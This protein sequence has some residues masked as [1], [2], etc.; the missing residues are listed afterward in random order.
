MLKIIRSG[1]LTTLQDG[2]RPGYQGM[3]VSP[4]GA[5]DTFAMQI[6]NTLVGNP[7][8]DAALEMTFQGAA[9]TF[10]CDT[11]IA[12][13]GAPI[14][15]EGKLA[16]LWRPLWVK[17][18]ITLDL[19]AMP[20]GARTYLCVQGGFEVPR[21]LGGAGTDL[22]N[23]FGGGF[24]RALSAGDSLAVAPQD[25][26]Y[27]SL[28]RR[29]Q[30]SDDRFVFPAW[31][32]SCWRD[33]LPFPLQA[34][35]FL[36][37][38]MGRED[39]GTIYAQLESTAFVVST[40]SDRQGLRLLGEPMGTTL[41]RQPSAGVCVGT[42][43]LPPDGQPILLLAD[44]Q[45]TGGY[46]VPGVVPTVAHSALAQARPGDRLTLQRMRLEEAHCAL[47]VR[48]QRLQL[49]RKMLHWKMRE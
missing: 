32:V 6:G 26:R 20:Q 24:G 7:A 1:V 21:V 14:L 48:E 17:A 46:P 39:M 4:G 30:K 3:G 36:P 9:I 45:T 40:A 35:P 47:W 13:T 22:R 16:P 34:L 11:L 5:A 2:G 28:Y 8:G 12:L 10:S 29:L 31:Q 38:P 43:Q 27:P 42:M 41:P 25:T 19:G 23:G 33:W 44:H 37:A 49:I 15:W 18:G